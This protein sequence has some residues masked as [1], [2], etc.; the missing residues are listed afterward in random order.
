METQLPFSS[1]RLSVVPPPN[2][3]Q[4]SAVP[5]EQI[6]SFRF[7]VISHVLSNMLKLMTLKIRIF[8]AKDSDARMHANTHTAHIVCQGQNETIATDATDHAQYQY[9]LSKN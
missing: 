3:T 5:V 7:T 8:T 9:E 1:I 2:R 4:P 6:E